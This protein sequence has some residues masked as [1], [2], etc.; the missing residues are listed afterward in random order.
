MIILTNTMSKFEA[1]SPKALVAYPMRTTIVPAG[2]A[3]QNATPIKTRTVTQT[4]KRT[5]EKHKDRHG[6]ILSHTMREE[7]TTEAKITY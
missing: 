4:F 5:E 6:Q 7:K 3:R 1:D 2:M